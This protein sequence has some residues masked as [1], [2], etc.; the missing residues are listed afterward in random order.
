MM[1]KNTALIIIFGDI[2]Q[3][4]M[5]VEKSAS[6]FFF[7]RVIAAQLFAQLVREAEKKCAFSCAYAKNKLLF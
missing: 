1:F 6:R 2:I 5:T 7:A 4:R 3:E